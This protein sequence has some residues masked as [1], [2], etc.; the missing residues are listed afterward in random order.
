MSS[1]KVA[2]KA[3][4]KLIQNAFEDHLIF[5]TKQVIFADAGVVFVLSELGASHIIGNEFM[6]QF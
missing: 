3:R 6:L 5:I 2:G 4:L 1:L